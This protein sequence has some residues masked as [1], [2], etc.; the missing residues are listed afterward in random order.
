M[1]AATVCPSHSLWTLIM[2]PTVGNRGLVG[3]SLEESINQHPEPHEIK[4]VVLDLSL[5]SLFTFDGAAV[6]TEYLHY[7]ARYN[8]VILICGCDA[9]TLSRLASFGVHILTMDWK[10]LGTRLWQSEHVGKNLLCVVK[11]EAARTR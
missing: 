4:V 6:L 5:V 3:A 10:E 2:T 1:S 8:F 11:A 7:S 9:E